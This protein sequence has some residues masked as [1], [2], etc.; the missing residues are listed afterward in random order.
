MVRPLSV[1]HTAALD[2]GKLVTLLLVSGHCVLFAGAR[3]RSVMTRS[4]VVMTKTTEQ[5]LIVHSVKSEAKVT[6]NNRLHSRH[7]IV[8]ATERHEA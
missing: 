3:Q 6:N 8:E 2:H 1:I 4:L 7:C 5:N